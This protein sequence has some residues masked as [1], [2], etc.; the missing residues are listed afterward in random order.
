MKSQ[1]IDVVLVER[2]LA[3]SREKAQAMV[4]AGQV[5]VD[6][7][8]IDKPG[9]KIAPDATIRLLG[10]PP[11]FVSRAGFKLEAA[12]ERFSIHVEGKTCLDIGSSTGGFTDCLL[13]H[14]ATKVYAVDAGTNQLHWKL[15]NDP[16]VQVREKV[17][18]RYLSKADVP[19]SCAFVCCDVSFISVTLILPVIND[20]V[21][22]DG[23]IVTLVKPQFEASRSEVGKGGVVRDEAV[24]RRAILRVREAVEA[25]GFRRIEEMESPITGAEGNREFLL[26]GSERSAA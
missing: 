5:L 2:E 11:R 6:E 1:R 9:R 26:W 16:R 7:Q 10:Q 24:H 15:R 3:E 4:L 19:E 17:N 13:Q 18:A 14:G 25:M 21:A 20:F 12:M 22:P 8:K 23:E